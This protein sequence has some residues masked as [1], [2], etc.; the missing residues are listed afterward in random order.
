MIQKVE[1][2]ARAEKPDELRS[3]RNAVM[4]LLPYAVW[5]ER[6]GQLE[7]LDVFLRAAGASKT[8][9]FGWYHVDRFADRLYIGASPRAVVLASSYMSWRVLTKN[10][11]LI[12]EWAKATSVVPYTEEVA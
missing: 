2:M 9:D 11:P 10:P 12:Q 8:L 3:K 1:A 6:D 4:A 7:M 5:Q